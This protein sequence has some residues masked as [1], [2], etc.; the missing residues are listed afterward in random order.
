[1]FSSNHQI[2]GAGV[3]V[4][5][6]IMLLAPA[7][8]SDSSTEPPGHS[9][10][11][12]TWAS[13]DGPLLG[14]TVGVAVAA[15]GSI[16]AALATG[17]LWRGSDASSTQWNRI[18]T[19]PLQD[20]VWETVARTPQ[21]AVLAAAG[22]AL[23]R[24][25]DG[26]RTWSQISGPPQIAHFAVSGDEVLATDLETIYRSADDGRSWT[27]L[28][29]GPAGT[30][31]V[32]TARLGEI[33]LVAATSSQGLRFSPD[34]GATWQASDV[35]VGFFNE[36][37][38]VPGGVVV[39]SRVGTGGLLRTTDGTSWEDV[40]PPLSGSPA[41]VDAL[42]A[43]DGGTVFAAHLN[44]LLRSADA[45]VTWTTSS[46]GTTARIRSVA[47]EGTD[48]LVGGDDGVWRFPAAGPPA[49]IG[50]PVARVTA[51]ERSV[52]GTIVVGARG[53]RFA[54]LMLLP[55]G[56]GW[57]GSGLGDFEARAIASEGTDVLA[58]TVGATE[59]GAGAVLASP[60]RGANWNLTL[61]LADIPSIALDASRR[62]VAIVTQSLGPEPGVHVSSDGGATWAAR[63][64]LGTTG[65]PTAAAWSGDLGFVVA[66][67]NAA[68][69]TSLQRST[70]G[71]Q[72][73]SGFGAGPPSEVVQLIV[74]SDGTT[75][76]ARTAEAGPHCRDAGE[77]I[78]PSAG[79]NGTV[80]TL[81]AGSGGD[82][83]A[84]S[85]AGV[86]RL[87]AGESTW[88]DQT[89]ALPAV[90]ITALWVG[91]GVIIAGSEGAGAWRGTFD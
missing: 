75:I 63:G 89:G 56:G 42:V 20:R 65:T 15:D 40:T 85:T 18:D 70:D 43:G 19:A 30:L 32:A 80:R 38:A 4:V 87:P 66:I 3:R 12:V 5:C 57:I 81:A 54:D 64:A 55:S 90:A 60:D 73:W 69:S 86:F 35:S 9:Q 72:S 47:P 46:A 44:L 51:V 58:A 83:W 33:G 25:S 49:R 27:T 50:V 39:A 11:T 62:A 74:L 41:F 16:V 17:S 59:S 84:G 14:E 71:G 37:V 67:R 53:G 26:G 31:T 7:A 21:G 22:N 8:C 88:E 34:D 79:L 77:W 6:L 45:G 78:E 10:E 76:C 13:L 23:F 48:P 28:G 29:P 91:D 24:S 1:M 36:A 68:E 82:L 2:G 61:G 52:N